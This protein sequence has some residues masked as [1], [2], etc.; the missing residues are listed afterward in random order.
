MI[1]E[2]L[3]TVKKRLSLCKFVANIALGVRRYLKEET[4]DPLQYKTH[5]QAFELH[6]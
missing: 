1:T 3:K 2:T 6:K 5:T 4:L